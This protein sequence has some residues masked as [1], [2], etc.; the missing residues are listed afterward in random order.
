[1]KKLIQTPSIIKDILGPDQLSEFSRAVEEIMVD[2]IFGLNENPNA[3][4]KVLVAE[5]FTVP[6]KDLFFRLSKCGLSDAY[7]DMLHYG[8]GLQK[9]ANDA[10]VALGDLVWLV[11]ATPL[12]EAD[13]D[14][15][16]PS[17]ARRK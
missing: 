1:M 17:K 8:T 7:C 2:A 5:C 3:R 9:A 14:E 12:H 6:L 10:G 11:A 13:K 15:I 4:L 16:K